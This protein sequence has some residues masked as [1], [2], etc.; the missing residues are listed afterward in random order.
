[1]ANQRGNRLRK[2]PIAKRFDGTGVVTIQASSP[3]WETLKLHE[4][5]FAPER[6]HTTSSGDQVVFFNPRSC[7]AG[8]VP[9]R[10][11]LE[12]PEGWSGKKYPTLSF[13]LSS[14]HT[15]ETLF[16][17]ADYWIKSDVPFVGITNKHG[18]IFSA[19]G[20]QSWAHFTRD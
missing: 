19:C 6:L 2:K 14:N 1:M 18:N 17:L 3:N 9:Y 20:L 8:G 16:M 15:N 13:V 11:A 10:V 5:P 12:R 7:G 4:I